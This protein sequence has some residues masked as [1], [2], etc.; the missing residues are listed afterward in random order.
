MRAG[1]RLRF[2][3]HFRN[4]GYPLKTFLVAC[5]VQT[6][7]PDDA[8]PE[9]EQLAVTTALGPR[10]AAILSMP[11]LPPDSVPCHERGGPIINFG[12]QLARQLLPELMGVAAV[13]L[14]HLRSDDL[15]KEVV[16][17]DPA[18]HPEAAQLMRTHALADCLRRSSSEFVEL[19]TTLRTHLAQAANPSGG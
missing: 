10:A 15:P 1:T 2:A 4:G 19:L 7:L 9:Q 16:A 12:L 6:D 18:I 17:M 11:D 13:P 3:R 5:V 14:W 8:T